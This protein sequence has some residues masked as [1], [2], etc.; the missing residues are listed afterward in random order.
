[1][2]IQLIDCPACGNKVSS[3]AVACPHCGQPIRLIPRP[4]EKPPFPK[5][6]SPVYPNGQKLNLYNGIGTIIILGIIILLMVR[7]ICEG[8]DEKGLAW[9]CIWYFCV[10]AW[11]AFHALKQND[12][13]KILILTFMPF[14]GIIF[15]SFLE[16]KETNTK[17]RN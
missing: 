7:S 16:P 2:S 17:N 13:G 1:M 6:A 11:Y 4:V 5:T 9:A 8:L 12:V 10:W 15:C 3:Q 14:I